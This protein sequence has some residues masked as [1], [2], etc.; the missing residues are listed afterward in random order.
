MHGAR[1]TSYKRRP[2]GRPGCTTGL[3]ERPTTPKQLDGVRRGRS[4]VGCRALRFAPHVALNTT[5]SSAHCARGCDERSFAE[6]PRQGWL[7]PTPPRRSSS[8]AAG[9]SRM[10]R[11]ARGPT[12]R[13]GANP[14]GWKAHGGGTA[15]NGDATVHTDVTRWVAALA[16]ALL[17]ERGLAPRAHPVRVDQG[18]GLLRGGDTTARRRAGVHGYQE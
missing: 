12:V 13:G 8:S 1:R 9:R 5:P 11:C 17:V 6:H 18:R 14:A 2:A 16:P 7:L 15:G 4:G 3:S 10:W